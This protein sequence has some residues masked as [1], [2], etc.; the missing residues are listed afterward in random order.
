MGAGM[1]FTARRKH[2][3]TQKLFA[4]LPRLDRRGERLDSLP[5]RVPRGRRGLLVG[6]RFAER[7]PQVFARCRAKLPAFHEAAGTFGALPSG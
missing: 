1:R 2:P 5:G 4:V 6:C 7:C 3:Y